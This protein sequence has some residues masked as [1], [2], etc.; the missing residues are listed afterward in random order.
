MA[1]SLEVRVPLLNH[2]LVQYALTIPHDLKLHGLTTKYVLRQSLKGILPEEI[3]KRPKKGFNMPVARW[4]HGP[5]RELV[6]DVLG[7]SRLSEAGLFDALYVKELLREHMEQRIDRRKELWTLL[8]FELWYRSLQAART[9]AGQRSRPPIAL[10]LDRP[11]A[12]DAS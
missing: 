7:P 9:E 12:I 1:C 5:L 2:N 8:T 4:I 6:H 10:Q 3:L 11:A